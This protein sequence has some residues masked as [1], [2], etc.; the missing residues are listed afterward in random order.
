M[1]QEF[2]TSE[3]IIGGLF[4]LM[5]DGFCAFLDIIGVGLIVGPVIHSGF[6]VTLWWW[7]KSKGDKNASN[8]GR[9]MARYFAT[10]VPVLPVSLATFAV[11][12]YVHNH[13][14][15]FGGATNMASTITK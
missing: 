2:N 5:V 15:K 1:S 12:T 6:S 10:I 7:L 4:A 11:E 9:Q 8:M 14:E 13:P 3:L